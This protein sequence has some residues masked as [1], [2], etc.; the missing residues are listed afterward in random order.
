MNIV[1]N[2]IYFAPVGDGGTSVQLADNILNKIGIL[3][4]IV[5]AIAVVVGLAIFGW[6]YTRGESKINVWAALG[7][8][9]VVLL[10]AG[11]ILMAINWRNFLDFAQ[12]FTQRGFDV[13][14]N[15]SN[16]FIN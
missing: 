16:E 15:V 7:K 6:N 8:L 1:K 14:Q 13:F 2:L 12:Q 11:F 4:I 9:A 10:I 5:I 3:A